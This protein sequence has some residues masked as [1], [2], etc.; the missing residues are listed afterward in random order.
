MSRRIFSGLFFFAIGVAAAVLILANPFDWD[1]AHGIQQ[2]TLSALSSSPVETGTGEERKISYW[3]AP[4][5]PTFISEQPG[6]S[7][8]GMDLIPVYEDEAEEAPAGEE[9]K[10]EYW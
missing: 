7:P 1:W 3:R 5:D 4:M 8:M 6:K 2:R 10:I 9:R